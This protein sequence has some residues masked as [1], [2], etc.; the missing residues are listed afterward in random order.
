MAFLVMILGCGRDTTNYTVLCVMLKK[1][2]LSFR[3]SLPRKWPVCCIGSNITSLCGMV[4]FATC[5]TGR[6]NSFWLRFSSVTVFEV[7]VVIIIGVVVWDRVIGVT[8]YISRILL[9][10]FSLFS[11]FFQ[12]AALISVMSWFFYS[13]GKLVWVCQH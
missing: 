7:V 4:R 12:Q 13:G 3:F 6:L 9:S 5:L 11:L 10:I 2:T 8:V 1:S